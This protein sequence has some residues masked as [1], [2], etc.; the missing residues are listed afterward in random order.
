MTCV[1]NAPKSTSAIFSL[2]SS[3]LVDD[4][5]YRTFYMVRDCRWWLADVHRDGCHRPIP[6]P[7]IIC[8]KLNCTIKMQLLLYILP[9]CLSV[10]PKKKGHLVD[11]IYKNM[12]FRSSNLAVRQS[13]PHSDM[14]G[15]V[16]HLLAR[17]LIR[18]SEMELP[19]LFSSIY[20][21]AL[22]RISSLQTHTFDVR[23]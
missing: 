9:I 13:F 2:S 12:T 10:V 4:K 23:F 16:V 7:N 20:L 22:I 14:H 8:W 17:S 5:L 6:L 11:H 1:N 21:W 18:F 19:I 3:R 15:H